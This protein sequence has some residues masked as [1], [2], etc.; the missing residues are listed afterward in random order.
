MWNTMQRA[1]KGGSMH[2]GMLHGPTEALIYLCDHEAQPACRLWARHY[3]I[4]VQIAG[5]DDS[6][7]NVVEVFMCGRSVIN[8]MGDIIE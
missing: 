5:H 8:R 1:R 4:L 3:H 7:S 6:K 2:H